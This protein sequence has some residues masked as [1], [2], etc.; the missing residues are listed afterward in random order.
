MSGLMVTEWGSWNSNPNLS[1]SSLGLNAELPFPAHRTA[2]DLMRPWTYTSGLLF[3][4]SSPVASMPVWLA[5]L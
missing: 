1:D 2:G 4:P 5:S 3:Q